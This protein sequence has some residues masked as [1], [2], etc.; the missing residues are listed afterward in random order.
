MI[1]YTACSAC[2]ELLS[3]PALAGVGG[4]AMHPQ[5]ATGPSYPEQ[6]QA[7]FLAAVL[8]GDAPTADALAET[9]DAAG[10]VTGGLLAAAVAYA[11]SGWPVF[12]CRP[13]DKTPATA[14][15]F[16]DA[17]TDTDRIERWWTRHPTC[18]IGVATGHAFDVI[19][20]DYQGKP[21]ALDWWLTVRDQSDMEIDALA[22]TPRGLHAYVTPN[23][24]GNSSK[25]FGINGVDYRG[26]GGYVV[27]PPS[28]REDGTYQWW[29]SP[30]PRI[31]Q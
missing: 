4:Y 12:P 18:N 15:G 24:A 29:V 17:T 1:T 5:C 20:I 30:S 14:H 11:R 19:D 13:G 31:K 28:T 16:H 26:I 25:L 23:G 9:L 27:V 8:A 21:D 3:V 7:A 6:L 2:G 22:T 10:S